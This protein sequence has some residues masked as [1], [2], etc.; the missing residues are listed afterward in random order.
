M[1]EE[2]QETT[3]RRRTCQYCV[4]R[5][6]E[7]TR[8]CST[9]KSPKT[10]SASHSYQG[11]AR[12]GSYESDARHVHYE[13]EPASASEHRLCRLRSRTTVEY[14]YIVCTRLPLLVLLHRRSRRIYVRYDTTAEHQS[15]QE[16]FDIDHVP[17]CDLAC[18]P[19]PNARVHTSS[20]SPQHARRA[21]S[22]AR[23]WR[24]NPR[25]PRAPDRCTVIRP[26]HGRLS[27][28]PKRSRESRG[29]MSGRMMT[30]ARPHMADEN[31]GRRM[32]GAGPRDG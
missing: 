5:E 21:N 22:R 15:V 10:R 12:H 17:F 19:K 11:P 27:P 2:T 26:P 30:W 23:S 18:L 24:A 9:S 31:E 1:T 7:Q 14:I 13:T 32:I 29:G 8:W 28:E 25:H 3:T 20:P 16:T 4:S 6:A